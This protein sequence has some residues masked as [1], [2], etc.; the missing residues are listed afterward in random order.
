VAG[1]PVLRDPSL[2]VADAVRRGLGAQLASSWLVRT[3]QRAGQPPSPAL[4]GADGAPGWRASWQVVAVDQGWERTLLS[5]SPATAGSL[6][7]DPA[8]LAGPL[9]VGRVLAE[10]L[11]TGCVQRD[12]PALRREL[13]RY[14]AWLAGQADENG[15]L[16][17][18]AVMA[19]PHNVVCH[20][21]R[22]AML[23]PSWAAGTAAP[24]PVALA[25]GLRQVATELMSHGHVHPWPSGSSL[26]D[27]T[28]MMAGAAGH[29]IDQRVVEQAAEL[30]AAL[31][32]APEPAGVPSYQQLSDALE[33]ASHRWESVQAKLAWYEW[34]LGSREAALRRTEFALRVL[35]TAPAYRIGRLVV[36]P[37]RWLR[38]RIRRVRARLRER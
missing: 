31:W 21:D 27:L 35:R 13:R 19:T 12:L 2:L 34:L 5:G 6:H 15:Q 9:P 25:R 28:V 38:T 14:A 10:V 11:V 30:S 8:A 37:A 26:A 17:G 1:R 36:A 3:G 23:D 16:P 18:R 7:R 24:L 29:D 22:P 4:L 33:R 20:G 32:P